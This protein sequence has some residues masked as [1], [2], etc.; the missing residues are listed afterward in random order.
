M[1]EK[2]EMRNCASYDETGVELSDCSKI[3]FIYGPNGSGKS[4]ISNFFQ[5]LT[6]S[7]YRDCSVTW[8]ISKPMDVLV[9]NRRFR[10]SNFS[11]DLVNILIGWY[12]FHRSNS[13]SKNCPL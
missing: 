13:A 4:T 9:Y 6:N 2:I 5:D 8:E 7:K 12:N 1:I 10:E 3:N 11:G